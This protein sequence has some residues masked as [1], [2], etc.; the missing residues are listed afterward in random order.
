MV[1]FFKAFGETIANMYV[2][3]A[4]AKSK[5]KSTCE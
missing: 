4:R 3:L 1:A 5:W 2:D